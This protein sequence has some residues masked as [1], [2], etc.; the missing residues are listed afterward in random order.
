MSRARRFIRNV[1]SGYLLLLAS[2]F[3]VFAS[4]PLALKFLTKEEFGLW[5]LMTQITGYLVLI[6]LGTSSSVSRLLIDRKDR[7]DEGEYGSLI[8]TGGLVLGCQGAIILFV[9]ILASPLASHL[10]QIPPNLEM[11]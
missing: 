7:P 1:T 6:D 2:M 10:L 8:Q 3:Y 11:S 5:A 9:G 4:V